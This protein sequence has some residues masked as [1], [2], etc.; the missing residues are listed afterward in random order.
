VK[1]EELQAKAHVVVEGQRWIHQLVRESRAIGIDEASA[2]LEAAILR[3]LR[4]VAGA[5]MRDLHEERQRS[6]DYLETINTVRADRNR[7]HDRAHAAE[8]R[9]AEAVRERDEW[10]DRARSVDQ[11]LRDERDHWSRRLA[12]ETAGLRAHVE[13][14]VAV[15]AKGV[16]LQTS[17]VFIARPSPAPTEPA[18]PS[19]CSLP[20]TGDV[21]LCP[22]SPGDCARCDAL[23]APPT[24]A[25]A[26]GTAEPP[27]TCISCQKTE[28]ECDCT[29]GFQS[30][31]D[32]ICYE[33]TGG[34]QPGCFYNDPSRVKAWEDRRKAAPGTEQKEKP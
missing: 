17:P 5:V 13:Q 25:P 19:H 23:R 18:C 2:D 34:H 22:C 30:E 11:A 3:A 1:D 28:A 31:P 15:I 6:R 14:L 29:G 16:A 7:E 27:E 32:C 33:M 10:V 20:D 12:N 21:A 24:E 26:P 9:L 8:A 4:E